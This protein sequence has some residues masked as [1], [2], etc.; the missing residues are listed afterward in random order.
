MLL[1]KECTADENVVSFIMPIH[2]QE[3]FFGYCMIGHCDMAT[4]ADLI[5]QLSLIHISFLDVVLNAIPENYVVFLIN[6]DAI[7]KTL[8]NN[9]SPLRM[10]YRGLGCTQIISIAKYYG[11][12]CNHI[13]LSLSLIHI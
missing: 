8:C 5:K 6:D 13:Q 11:F 10:F 12:T 9:T 4:E 7:I 2:Y 1:P 3:H